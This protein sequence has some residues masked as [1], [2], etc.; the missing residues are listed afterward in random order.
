MLGN[1][2][3]MINY[4]YTQKP[5]YYST[6]SKVKKV[7]KNAFEITPVKQSSHNKIVLKTTASCL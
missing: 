4:S 7:G 1:T 2:S 5:F 3:V 6:F